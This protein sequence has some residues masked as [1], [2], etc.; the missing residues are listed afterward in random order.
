M[1]KIYKIDIVDFTLTTHLGDIRYISALKILKP[2]K[3]AKDRKYD[4]VPC[5]LVIEMATPAFQFTQCFFKQMYNNFIQPHQKATLKSKSK[6]KLEHQNC[7]LA[8]IEFFISSLFYFFGTFPSE[9]HPLRILETTTLYNP[10]LNFASSHLLDPNLQFQNLPDLFHKHPQILVRIFASLLLE[11]KIVF[12][13][14]DNFKDLS[15]QKD[16][17]NV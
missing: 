7:P 11:Y 1:K 10:H 12:I 9:N 8:S 16:C 3:N 6:Q 17:D 2:V 5:L 15:H 4:L 13:V 14:P